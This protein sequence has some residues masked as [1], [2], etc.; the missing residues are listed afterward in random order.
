MYVVI[1]VSTDAS[2]LMHNALVGTLMDWCTC[3]FEC[4]CHYVTVI[5]CLIALE[6]S[7][8]VES[9]PHTLAILFPTVISHILSFFL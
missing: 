9:H 6:V 4:I 5:L 3:I 2:C 8:K 7:Q 1:N